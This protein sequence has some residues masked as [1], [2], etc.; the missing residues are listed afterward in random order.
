MRCPTCGKAFTHQGR[1]IDVAH[2][3]KKCM[4]RKTNDGLMKL[5]KIK[6]DK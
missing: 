1:F 3:C 5:I 6:E 4:D 2:W